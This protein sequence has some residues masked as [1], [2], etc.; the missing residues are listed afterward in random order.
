MTA[1]I[2]KVNESD[3]NCLTKYI[4]TLDTYGDII[5]NYF[6]HRDTSGWVEGI[7]NKVKVIKR[8]CY[9]L[10]NLKH[11]FQRIFLDF[12]GYDIFLGKQQ[13]AST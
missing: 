7:N 13:V 2:T 11:F 12:Q 3:T 6:I 9:G 5:S 8:R 1:W 10:T 4:K